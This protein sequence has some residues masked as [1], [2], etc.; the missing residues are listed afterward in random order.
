MRDILLTTLFSQNK[1]RK[2][3]TSALSRNVRLNGNQY[4]ALVDWSFNAGCPGATGS[5][6]I[7]RL[8]AGEDPNTVAAEELPKWNKGRV[9]GQLV[10]LPVLVRRRATEV[11]LFQTP[12][13]GFVLPAC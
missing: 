8:N 1:G 13:D 6:L 10:V 11:A 7:R 5:T 12:S 4:G 3:I 9:N 2:C